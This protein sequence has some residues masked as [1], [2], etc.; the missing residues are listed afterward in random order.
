MATFFR[1]EV[2]MSADRLVVVEGRDSRGLVVHRYPEES[3]KLFW[4]GDRA[5]GTFGGGPPGVPEKVRE[6]LQ[7]VPGGPLELAGAI[8]AAYAG[9]AVGAF[10][11]GYDAEGPLIA[12]AQAGQPS[13]AVFRPT[14]PDRSQ[15][16]TCEAGHEWI[17]QPEG[18]A[19]L[20]DV[21]DFMISQQLEATERNQDT[22]GPPFDWV[23]LH[24]GGEPET[25]RG[26]TV[27]VPPP[28]ADPR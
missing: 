20:D 28:P 26:S 4:R 10:V 18:L 19:S 27:T 7:V 6:L 15:V 1:G 13:V 12:R 21:R 3:D 2:M 11:G 22:V 23:V 5:V 8:S 17:A 16:W 14:S 24:R 25:W 9:H